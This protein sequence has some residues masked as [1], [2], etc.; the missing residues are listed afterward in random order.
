MLFLVFLFF[1]ANVSLSFLPFFILLTVFLLF[2][3]NVL[4]VFLPRFVLLA[5]FLLFRTNVSLSF[6]PFFILLTVFL[7]FRANVSLSFLLFFILLTVFSFFRAN[8]FL[9]FLL[10]FVLLAAF[11]LL[12]A[13][14][15]YSQP[16][17]FCFPAC[18]RLYPS[19]FSYFFAAACFFGRS[20]F[21]ACC[22]SS[23]FCWF[24]SFLGERFPMLSTVLHPLDCFFFLSDE[25]LP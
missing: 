19:V 9:R 18:S 13:I 7:L 20:L 21:E 11:P 8:I 17:T 24:S 5:V 15:S 10:H 14:F 1:W 25:C 3:A 23:C 16:S 22:Q 6:L 4:L 12:W 2:R